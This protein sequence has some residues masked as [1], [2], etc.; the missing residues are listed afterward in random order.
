MCASDDEDTDDD[1]AV[2]HSQG[3]QLSMVCPI[4]REAYDLESAPHVPLLNSKC[5]HTY[6]RQ[7]I[8]H[9]FRGGGTV[10][11]PVPGCS[12]KIVRRADLKEDRVRMALLKKAKRQR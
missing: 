5:D 4:T 1:I 10:T 2:V 9:L 11:C 12:N 6:S 3:H 7:G 8:E